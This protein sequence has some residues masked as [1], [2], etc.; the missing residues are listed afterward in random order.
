MKG[1]KSLGKFKL[2]AGLLVLIIAFTY[3]LN[4]HSLTFSKISGINT[5]DDTLKSEAFIYYWEFDVDK[6]ASKRIELDNS[7]TLQ[8]IKILD[9][10]SYRR[11]Y[12]YS[13]QG[14]VKGGISNGYN[15][16]IL[17]LSNTKFYSRIMLNE[18]GEVVVSLIEDD[19]WYKLDLFGNKN[20]IELFKKVMDYFKV[21][22]KKDLE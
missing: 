19:K 8:L 11:S 9:E 16:D 13:L 15:I 18:E 5:F 14:G 22:D 20:G 12:I 2:A 3:I 1:I 21:Y 7:Q 4:S 6:I 17:F 10:Y